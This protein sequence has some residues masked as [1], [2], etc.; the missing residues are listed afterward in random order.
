M[1]AE[2]DPASAGAG[3]AG[4]RGGAGGTGAA[5]AAASADGASGTTGGGGGTSGSHA[6]NGGA[7]SGG[8]DTDADGGA[9]VAPCVGETCGDGSCA[10]HHVAYDA[11]GCAQ[12]RCS[13]GL[14]VRGACAGKMVKDLPHVGPP[15][16]VDG[17]S[18][19]G[20][21][22]GDG[23]VEL[24]RIDDGADSA[25]TVTRLDVEYDDYSRPVVDASYVYFVLDTYQGRRVYRTLKSG[26]PYEVIGQE[27]DDSTNYVDIAIDESHVYWRGEN[28]IFRVP[29]AG[30]E[31]LHWQHLACG[32]DITV[33]GGWAY[34]SC[35]GA[36]YRR[37]TSEPE[38]V[39][40]FDLVPFAA[41]NFHPQ[42]MAYPVASND[43][44]HYLNG[45]T[46]ESVSLLTDETHS[47]TLPP[48]VVVFDI[49]VDGERLFAVV[50]TDDENRTSFLVE[51]PKLGEPRFNVV[52]DLASNVGRIDGLTPQWL[53]LH[54]YSEITRIPRP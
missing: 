12:S 47:Y 42:A 23:F 50:A 5:G 11:C 25:E 13:E 53:Y 7:G 31:T 21:N 18:V 20:L 54:P 37:R 32:F 16:A 2:P 40:S 35:D 6:G 15:L 27:G 26:G 45:Q 19:Y 49:W 41:D 48:F 51:F 24:Y 17:T 52:A 36:M 28:G 43:Q 39:L 3:A 22:I 34:F 4:A 46:V 9:V 8:M 29:L 38:E 1:P 14:C 10:E 30:G 33:A 44:L